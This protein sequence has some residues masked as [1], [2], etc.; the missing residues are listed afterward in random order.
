MTTDRPLI[1]ASSSRYRAQ[2]LRDAGI[3]VE[4]HTPDFD[5][6]SLD[7]HFAAWGVDRYVVEVALGKA[8]SVATTLHGGIVV[9]ADQAAVHHGRLLTKPGTAER[10]VAQLCELSG[11]T[12]D[13]VNGLAVMVVGGGP[14]VTAVDRHRVTMAAFS[15]AEARAYVAEFQPFDCVGAYRI[16][17]DAGLIAAVEGS[18]DDGVIGMPVAALRTLLGRVGVGGQRD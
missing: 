18:G 12:H 4:V 13:L 14:V 11:T 8:A 9:G 16:E 10:A 6:R 1:L 15:P 5:E 7:V 2:V 3:A 17:D